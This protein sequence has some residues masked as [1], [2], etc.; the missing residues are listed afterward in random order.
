MNSY[1]EFAGVYDRLM[2]DVDYDAWS[3]YIDLLLRRCFAD[4]PGVCALHECACGTGLLST[5]L[6]ALGYALTASDVSTDMLRV[7]QEKAMR[8]G[9]R[10]PFV[11]QDM[12]HLTLHKPVDAIIAACDGANYLLGTDDLTAFFSAA[13]DNLKPDGV[14]LFDCSTEYKLSRVI[15]YHTF[16]E[17]DGDVAYLW[18]NAYDDRTRLS[19]MRL[20]VFV[21]E[22]TLYKRFTERHVQRAHRSAE[23]QNALN[24]CGFNRIECFD[25]FTLLPE[26][27]ASERVQWVARR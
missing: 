9:Q 1:G 14:L 17:D 15:G 18:K 24:R 16:G 20:S 19:E 26:T 2:S 22:G 21:R 12:R 8:L 6:S 3:A 13:L 23:I 27:E 5:R 4:A 25:A 11:R 7:A 10:I